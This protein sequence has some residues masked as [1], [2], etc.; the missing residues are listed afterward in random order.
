MVSI[1]KFCLSSNIPIS[2]IDHNTGK[3]QVRGKTIRDFTA[4][5]TASLKNFPVYERNLEDFLRLCKSIPY[6]VTLIL[7]TPYLFR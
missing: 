2:L 5:M 4:F 7:I 6:D 3:M 1:A